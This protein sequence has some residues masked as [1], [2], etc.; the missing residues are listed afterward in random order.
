LRVLNLSFTKLQGIPKSIGRLLNL[1]YL[2]L[3]GCSELQVLPN[4]IAKLSSLRFLRLNET[5]ITLM[6][7]GIGG[8]R[9]LDMLMGVFESSNGFKLDEL[10][11][12]SQLRRLRIDKLE[13]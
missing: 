9:H 11:S 12:L 13:E 6:P 1:H 5:S 3:L 4:S 7:R 10:Q 2:S 8:L